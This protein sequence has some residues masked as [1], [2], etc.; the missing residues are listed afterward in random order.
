M[1]SIPRATI[2][3]ISACLLYSSL[4]KPS[5]Y[6]QEVRTLHDEAQDEVQ[7]R[8]AVAFE[9]CTREP[10]LATR[11]PSLRTPNATQCGRLW[12]VPYYGPCN[13]ILQQLTMMYLADLVKCKPEVVLFDVGRHFLDESSN[14]T[15][16]AT[17]EE[18]YDASS[19]GQT[20]FRPEH[21]IGDL[22]IIEKTNSQKVQ[23]RSM[24]KYQRMMPIL[25]RTILHAAKQHVFNGT[26]ALSEQ[27]ETVSGPG[28][29]FFK[30]G[31][32]PCQLTPSGAPKC[33]DKEQTWLFSELF[34][35][36]SPF[37]R[38]ENV[39]PEPPQFVMSAQIRVLD[40]LWRTDDV[41]DKKV[42][43]S[44]L[45]W[46]CEKQPI[47]GVPFFSLKDL[48]NSLITA[49]SP[50]PIYLSAP[51]VWH[52]WEE[53]DEF[54]RQS[55]AK[56][57]RM[58]VYNVS[59]FHSFAPEMLLDHQLLASAS[60]FVYDDRSTYSL[61]AMVRRHGTA[62]ALSMTDFIKK[63]HQPVEIH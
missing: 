42:N 1:K 29:E 61:A 26:V 31:W 25:N 47:D 27:I 40:D 28:R 3:L 63:A 46:G 13:I 60:T 59:S 37:V 10:C 58:L 18:L 7:P 22:D 34:G 62:G 50:G 9:V 45:L 21:P 43:A 23:L 56:T 6:L 53:V 2:L 36:T 11:T 57:G 51:P 17:L 20:S 35:D 39:Q 30:V 4:T 15:F 19:F 32:D 12:A 33:S 49:F 44:Q 38:I 8:K 41:M 16:I 24:K 48:L 5:Q 52:F 55:M 14:R 54:N